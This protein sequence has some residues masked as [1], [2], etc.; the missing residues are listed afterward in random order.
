MKLGFQV[1]LRGDRSVTWHTNVFV[2]RVVLW[3]IWSNDWSNF[4]SCSSMSMLYPRCCL[5]CKS[6]KN[7]KGRR[8]YTFLERA[9][10]VFG[11]FFLFRQHFSVSILCSYK[12][13]SNLNRSGFFLLTTLKKYE[14]KQAGIPY[15]WEKP[16]SSPIE[17]REK[18][19]EK[20]W[21]LER[22]DYRPGRGSQF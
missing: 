18:V 16:I 9:K 6:R 12:S 19:N 1:E 11:W 13:T 17:Y 14:K 3:L 10:K 5:W 2:S 22:R 7:A 20:M 8:F 4:C 21:G 15:G